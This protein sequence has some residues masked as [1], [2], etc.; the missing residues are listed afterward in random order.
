MG[1]SARMTALHGR[2]AGS[3]AEH[4]CQADAVGGTLGAILAGLVALTHDAACNRDIDPEAARSRIEWF[5]RSVHTL[6]AQYVS[7]H[8]ELAVSAYDV[9]LSSGL[10]GREAA[11][12]QVYRRCYDTH[13]ATDP[14][15]AMNAAF[16][17]DH[18]VEAGCMHGR[19]IRAW[20]V[21][22]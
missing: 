14:Q 4:G 16:L 22:N 8:Y 20:M 1:A 6:I 15:G 3:L 10:H 9:G 7:R 11:A 17:T 12:T 21:E 18:L 13:A 19:G 5:R 2:R